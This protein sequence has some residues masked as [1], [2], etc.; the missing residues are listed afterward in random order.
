MN[1][2]DN[3][4]FV[5]NPGQEDVG[6]LGFANPPDGIGNVCQC[7]DGTGEGQANATDAAFIKRQALGLAAPLFLVPDNCD[8]SGNEKCNGT[9]ATLIVHA[10][11]GN[12]SPLFG[13]NC[14]SALP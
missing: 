11:L 9:D 1:E 8:V 2:F 10:A 3:C 6:G 14:P 4:P 5:S 12:V 7:G 13:Q